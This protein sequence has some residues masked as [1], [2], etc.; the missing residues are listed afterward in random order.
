LIARERASD[1]D[2]T[3]AELARAYIAWSVAPQGGHRAPGQACLQGCRNLA[4][5][6]AWYEAG[7]EDAGGCGSVMRVFP[8]G[9]LYANDPA[10]AEAWAVAHSKLTH[11]APIALAACAAMTTVVAQALRDLPLAATM[12]SAVEAA[13]R[14]DTSTA[15]LVERAHHDALSGVPPEVTLERLQGWAAHEAIA[16][17]AYVVT[18]HPHDLRAG[19]LEAAN[20]PGDSD[21]IASLVGAWLG[22]R[23]GFAHIPAEWIDPLER[24][25]ELLALA[26]RTADAIDLDDSGSGLL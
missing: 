26:N 10:R 12:E 17:A 15:R 2:Q 9:L 23:L 21:S 24:S 6:R 5:G 7:E 1:L 16:A 4:A 14:Y 20:T 11:R 18:R 19:L 13:R 8:F 3:M 22:A 25:S